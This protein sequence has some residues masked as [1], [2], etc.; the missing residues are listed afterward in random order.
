MS[1]PISGQNPSQYTHPGYA[2][3]HPIIPHGV[4]V[5]VTAPAVVRPLTPPTPPLSP[6]H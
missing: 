5:A 3:P 6:I 1:Y 2:V 4:S